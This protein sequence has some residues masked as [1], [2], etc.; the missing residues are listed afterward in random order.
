MDSDT[1]EAKAL[2]SCGWDQKQPPHQD[3]R[4]YIGLATVPP[5]II[6]KDDIED[7]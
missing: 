2:T 7:Q 5:Q 3:R 4:L 1:G 6:Y